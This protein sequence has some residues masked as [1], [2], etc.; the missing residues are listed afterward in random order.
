MKVGF[1]DDHGRTFGF[2]SIPTE[3][4]KGPDDAM[5]RVAKVAHDMMR[6]IGIQ[7]KQFFRAG[8]GTPGSMDISKGLLVAPPNH[9]NWWNFPI[10]DCLESKLD[11]EVSFLNDANAAAAG[12]WWVGTGK[13][14]D[15]MALL[16]LGTGVGG[17]LISQGHL[18]NGENSFGSECGHIIIDSHPDA[19]LCVW[20]GGRGHLEAYASA[21]GVAARANELAANDNTSSMAR[22]VGELTAKNVYEH[23]EKNDPLALEIIDETA[24]YLGIGIA[25]I[26][27]CVDPGL[28]VLGGAMDF[29]GHNAAS[30]RRFLD[31]TRASFRRRTFDYVYSGT[32]IDFAQLGGDAGYLGAA[33]I[34]RNDSMAARSD[35]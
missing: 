27:H 24:D 16:T 14:C 29:G 8:L 7:S 4:P 19:R 2:T 33:A 31:K 18:I 30:G 9:P 23:A 3:E 5:Q 17:G 34:A 15:S 11:L 35:S 21:S 32:R 12:E 25:N 22:F 6:E 26:V 28:V 10:R 20:G 13:K 1:V